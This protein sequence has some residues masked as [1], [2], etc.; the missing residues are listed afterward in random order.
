MRN[1]ADE[2]QY[3]EIKARL[4]KQLD[5]WM[6]QQGDQGIE[7]EM[8]AKTLQCAERQA[9]KAAAAEAAPRNQRPPH[10]SL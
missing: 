8:K 5:D 4:Q 9:R 1:L 3:A 10:A 6:T 7:N 2:P